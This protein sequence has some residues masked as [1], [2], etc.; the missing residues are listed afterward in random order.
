MK[1]IQ[2]RHEADLL[3]T[4]AMTLA[5]AAFLLCHVPSVHLH[6]A[7]FAPHCI[8]KLSDQTHG[9]NPRWNGAHHHGTR[10]T[11]AG[12]EAIFHF[13]AADSPAALFFVFLDVRHSRRCIQYALCLC[14]K[15]CVCVCVCVYFWP[16]SWLTCCACTLRGMV[17]FCVFVCVRSGV[18]SQGVLLREQ[19]S[20]EG[21][22]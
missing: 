4:A 9:G 14:I 13:S 16:L 20:R 15:V 5:L 6:V 3:L 17:R 21:R 19:L 1:R 22:G 7:P 11:A 8:C 10:K 12:W 18:P 2:E